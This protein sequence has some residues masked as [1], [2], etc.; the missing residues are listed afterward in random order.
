MKILFIRHGESLDDVENRYG[1][2][3]DFPLTEK[4][5][6]QIKTKLNSI[7]ELNV[8]FE[9]I[10]TSPLQR[11]IRSAEI[12][13]TGLNIPVE[14][15]EYIKERNTYGLLSGM[16]KEEATKK[17]PDQVERLNN[18][19][20]VDGS[21]RYADLIDRIKTSIRLV[22]KSKYEKVIV[23]THGKY[24]ICLFDT[25]LGKK[26]TKKED[27]GF[28]LIALENGEM[29]IISSSGIEYV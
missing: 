24:L 6:K 10:F 2:W 26:L 8:P 21:E 7:K 11:A 20:Y 16:K 27:G 23:V 19:K 29:E 25:I 28:V 13:S 22:E 15:M 1:G 4:G 14:T 18:D 17:Y 9:I 12:L 3:A 5:E